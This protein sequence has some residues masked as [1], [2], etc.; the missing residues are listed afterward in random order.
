MTTLN[1]MFNN[2]LTKKY[3][4]YIMAFPPPKVSLPLNLGKLTNL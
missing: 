4:M 1:F 3:I 2:Y